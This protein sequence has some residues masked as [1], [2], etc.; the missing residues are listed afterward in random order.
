MKRAF[1]VAAT[2]LLSASD[3]EAQRAEP[4]RPAAVVPRG[5]QVEP[6]YFEPTSVDGEGGLGFSYSINLAI[7]G[8]GGGK[9]PAP[10][11]AA[12]HDPKKLRVQDAFST[13]SLDFQA[14]GNVALNQNINPSDFL[15]TGLD[16]AYV[17]SRVARGELDPECDLNDPDTVLKCMSLA[18]SGLRWEAAFSGSLESDQ[19]FDRQA[20]AYGGKAMLAYVPRQNSLLNR[21]N[22]LDW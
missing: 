20:K 1:A 21:L 3:A 10:K 18:M 6:K 15:K 19:K 14:R 7:P 2:G 11:P 13:V 8:L 22:V 5:I 12:L 17:S 9:P 16:L 4:P